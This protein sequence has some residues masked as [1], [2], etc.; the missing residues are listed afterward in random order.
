MTY[1]R[2]NLPQWCP[3]GAPLFLTGRLHGSLPTIFFDRSGKAGSFTPGEVFR[4]ADEQLDR[5]AA[6][7]LWLKDPRVAASVVEKI[8]RGDNELHHYSLHAYFVMSNHVHVLLTPNIPLRR[9]TDSLKGV[10]A[11]TANQILRRSGQHFWQDESCD[12]WC[13]NAAEFER[14]R[15]YVARNPVSASL[16]AKPED[17]PWSSASDVRR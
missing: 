12:H 6:G 11:R 3:N 9:V 8:A 17:W 2:S 16:V 14:I 1:Y 13:R 10:T 7:P 15:G 5:A 4:R